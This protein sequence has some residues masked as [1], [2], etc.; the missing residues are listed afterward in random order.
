[1]GLLDT[2]IRL[3]QL[4]SGG[5]S[6]CNGKLEYEIPDFGWNTAIVQGR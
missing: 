1:M 2:G 6:F 5:W 3:D 4:G